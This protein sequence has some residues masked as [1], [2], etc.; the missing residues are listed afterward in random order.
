M[1]H[2]QP[3]PGSPASPCLCDRHPSGDTFLF[4]VEA[5]IV[6]ADLVGGA[7]RLAPPLSR[8][9]AGWRDPRTPVARLGRRVERRGRVRYRARGGNVHYLAFHAPLLLVL[10]TNL[11]LTA[12][13]RLAPIV[14]AVGLAV[15]L[16]GALRD[17][18]SARRR[19]RPA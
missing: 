3:V 18:L 16:A 7:A 6:G 14:L 17:A 15:A 12:G 4:P 8:D 13:L 9:G 11:T 1:S 5:R 2:W 19:L 10:Q